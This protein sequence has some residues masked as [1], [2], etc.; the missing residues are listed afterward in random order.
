MDKEFL[1]N[2]KLSLFMKDYI[3][4]S[5]YLFG[6]EI[7]TKVSSPAKKGLQN[8]YESSKRLE[9]KYADIFH[10][11]VAKLL[12]VAKRGRPDIEPAISFLYTRVTKSTKEDKEN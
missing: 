1:A 7:S 9:N 10:C 4:E 12:W 8:I 3:E 2:G 5:I 6:G 11:I